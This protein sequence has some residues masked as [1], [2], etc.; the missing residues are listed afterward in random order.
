M[1]I[2]LDADIEF[3]MAF[4]KQ[5]KSKSEIKPKTDVQDAQEIDSNKIIEH[6][7]EEDKTLYEKF[8]E[9]IDTE[10]KFCT[11]FNPQKVFRTFFVSLL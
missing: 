10:N 5:P 8:K 11:K 7:E 1:A 9:F 6:V 3:K 4:N 2:Q